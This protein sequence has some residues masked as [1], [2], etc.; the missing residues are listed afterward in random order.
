MPY[1]F[2][3]QQNSPIAGFLGNS[4]NQTDIVTGSQSPANSALG[5]VPNY[6]N[7]DNAGYANDISAYRQTSQTDERSPGQRLAEDFGIEPMQITR[8]DPAEHSD[9]MER[10]TQRHEERTEELGDMATGA[11]IG[12]GISAVVDAINMSRSGQQGDAFTPTHPVGAELGME[13]LARL[14]HEDAAY[15][16]A[17]DQHYEEI[18]QH[19]MAEEQV[20]QANTQMLNEATIANRQAEI[21]ALREQLQ[22]IKQAGGIEGNLGPEHYVNMVERLMSKG[23]YEKAF[24]IGQRYGV[25]DEN[26]EVNYDLADPQRYQQQPQPGSREIQPGPGQ[27]QI[28]EQMEAG[29]TPS[30]DP[31]TLAEHGAGAYTPSA[32]DPRVKRK[33]DRIRDREQEIEQ[34]RSRKQQLMDQEGGYQLNREEIQSI[35][36]DIRGLEQE[37]DGLLEDDNVANFYYQ[38]SEAA[39]SVGEVLPQHMA[40]PDFRNQYQFERAIRDPRMEE[41]FLRATKRDIR[42]GRLNMETGIE[43]I[44]RL[45]QR[46]D[47]SEDEINRFIRENVLP[48]IREQDEEQTDQQT[49]QGQDAVSTDTQPDESD[50]T[51]QEGQQ[52]SEV[53]TNRLNHLSRRWIDRITG[54]ADQLERIDE[55]ER[56]G[57]VSQRG[58][59]AQR[60]RQQN[61]LNNA[62]NNLLSTNASIRNEVINYLEQNRPDLYERVREHPEFE[63]YA[64]GR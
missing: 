41:P 55:L 37:V 23:Q 51:E 10:L 57:T 2:R 50:I 20:H 35:N 60:E 61:R 39:D 30:I 13:A 14:E 33:A 9:R 24:D 15:Q 63:N 1:P 21:E 58:V 5:F 54:S 32:A 64:E 18:M 16:Q 3:K 38:H 48:E 22:D 11:A 56:E 19:A 44:T 27:Q 29:E 45:L 7:H 62:M 42:E 8:D 36:E 43:R 31:G 40:D 12:Q 26:H 53:D 46:Y 47:H 17:L 28:A 25:F 34:M 6:R 49:E 4:E 52:A 59:D